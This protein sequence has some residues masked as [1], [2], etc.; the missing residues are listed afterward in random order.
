[1][2]TKRPTATCLRANCESHKERHYFP[3]LT[4]CENVTWQHFHHSQG[5]LDQQQQL[6]ILDVDVRFSCTDLY[7]IPY[8][9]SESSFV[10]G[11]SRQVLVHGFSRTEQTGVGRKERGHLHGSWPLLDCEMECK[12]GTPLV[13]IW[14]LWDWGIQRESVWEREPG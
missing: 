13:G 1:M 6:P 14:L 7:V 2:L 5:Q 11:K 3:L 9:T 12:M 4:A 10:A 8:T